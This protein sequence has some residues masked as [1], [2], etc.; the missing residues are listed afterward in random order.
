M[1]NII[2]LKQLERTLAE[3]TKDVEAETKSGLIAAGKLVEGEAKKQI[4]ELSEGDEV[5]RSRNGGGTYTHI[6]SKAGDAPN[7]DTG[8]LIGSI[9]TE[10]SGK[11][12]FV[13]TNVEYA[14]ALEFGT[15]S[16]AARPFLRPALEAKRGDIKKVLGDKI[17]VA[18]R[19]AKSDL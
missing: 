7:T 11:S 5:I 12:V 17:S 4:A 16:M 13:G 9:Q 6:A 10:L 18:I 2:G 1:T 3:L 19:S 8:R 15:T 14:P